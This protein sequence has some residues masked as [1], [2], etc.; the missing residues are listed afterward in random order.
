MPSGF[1]LDGGHH[2]EIGGVRREKT[3]YV[4]PAATASVLSL[5]VAGLLTWLWPSLGS[6]RG[7]GVVRASCGCLNTC[8]FFLNPT[9]TSVGGPFTGVS[10]CEAPGWALFAARAM[11]D[12][13][14]TPASPVSTPLLSVPVV[15]SRLV[16]TSRDS[17]ARLTGVQVLALSLSA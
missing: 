2:Q 11:P 15:S 7:L 12:D 13:H 6:G 8:I 14:L 1:W 17:G 9:Y 16:I 4:L 3:E 5:A 10:P